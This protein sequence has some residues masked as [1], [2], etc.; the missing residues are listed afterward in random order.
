MFLSSQIG[1]VLSRQLYALKTVSQCK[2][3]IF[4]E[5]FKSNIMMSLTAERSKNLI[6]IFETEFRVRG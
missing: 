2:N 4:I 1:L 3:K 6:G 5:K